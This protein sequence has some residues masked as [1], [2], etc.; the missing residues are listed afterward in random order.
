LGERA[1]GKVDVDQLFREVLTSDPPKWTGPYPNATR[2]YLFGEVWSRPVLS[3]RDRRLVTLACVAAASLP[4]AV[5]SHV[6]SALV[7]DDVGL[8]EMLEIVLQFAVYN[9]WARASFFEG[10]VRLQWV[11]ICQE[12]GEEIGEWPEPP[13][14]PI[15]LDDP[16]ALVEAGERTY[17][18]IL[19]TDPP[20]GSLLQE[21]AVLGFVYARVWARPTLPRRDRRILT[22]PWVAMNG[23]PATIRRHLGG[24]LASGDLGI[25]ELD[26][27][28][29]QMSAYGGLLVGERLAEAVEEARAGDA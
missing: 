14:V 23:S 9:G 20:R 22:L 10:I 5:E 16:D 12:R 17:A 6:Y 27:L 3:R 7:S 15:G 18:E 8:D 29:L 28:V 19:H 25:A 1:T 11:R 4:I 24:A 26:E 13:D 21:T 2:D